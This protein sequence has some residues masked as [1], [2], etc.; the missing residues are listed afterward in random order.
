[1][2]HLE[3]FFL[4]LSDGAAVSDSVAPVWASL[5]RCPTQSF[6]FAI[7]C[8]III[9]IVCHTAMWKPNKLICIYFFS[10]RK[11]GNSDD[12]HAEA[13]EWIQSRAI[14]KNR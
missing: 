9:I 7:M 12:N 10:R 4:N 2:I 1:M 3:I 13:I 11:K 8:V 5:C 6:I 14:F